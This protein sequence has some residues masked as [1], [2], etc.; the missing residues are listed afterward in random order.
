SKKGAPK[1]INKYGTLE[2]AIEDAPNMSSKRHRE[3]LQK[4][5]EEAL[6]A[7][8]MVTIKTDVPETLPWEKLGWEGADR[9]ELGSF[10]KRMEFRTLTK[11]Y[12]DEEIIRASKKN[13]QKG[14][15][16]SEEHTSELQS[17]FDLVCR[18]LL[19]KK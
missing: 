1:L 17:R 9:E 5:E 11:K 18:L 19:E 15:K 8:E 12:L 7:K 14:H 16:R 6:H 10:F 2:A 3:G 4:Y 13:A